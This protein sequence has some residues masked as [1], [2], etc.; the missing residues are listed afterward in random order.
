MLSADALS[1]VA[2]R[3]QAMLAVLVLAGLPGLSY[4]LP[5]GAAIVSLMLADD[6]GPARKAAGPTSSPARN[7][8]AFPA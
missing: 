4:S 1:W 5:A 2:Y 8:A 3:P 7:S 6:P